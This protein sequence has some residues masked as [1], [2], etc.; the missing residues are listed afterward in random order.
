MREYK[1]RQKDKLVSVSFWKLKL[2][3]I[4]Q[5]F[6]NV[7]I[8]SSQEAEATTE[9]QKIQRQKKHKN[10]QTE[11]EETERNRKKETT[12]R[13]KLVRVFHFRN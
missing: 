3:R 1:V 13:D 10:R 6:Q 8:F 9:R 2:N 11:K 4:S 7:F 5:I 12:E